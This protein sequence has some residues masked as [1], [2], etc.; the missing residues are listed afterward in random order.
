MAPLCASISDVL[1]RRSGTPDSF[2]A[3][4]KMSRPPCI[5]LSSRVFDM[6]VLRPAFEAACPAIDLRIGSDVEA[7]G[8]L[9]QI[10]AAVCW[11]PSHGLLARLPRLKLVQSLAAT[12]A[13]GM[14]A[15]VTWAVVQHHRQMQGY[16]ANRAARQWRE[17]AITPPASHVVGIAGLGALGSA[18]ASALVA[19]GYTVR[20]WSRSPRPDLPQGVIGFHGP[21]QLDPFLAGCHALVCLL[22]LTP[23]TLGFL[24]AGCFDKLA[25]G[26]HIVNVGRGDHLVEADL[27]AALANGQVGAATLDTFSEEPLPPGHAFW[28]EPKILVTPH[29]ATRSAP[30]VM[31][32]QT[33]ANLDAVNRGVEPMNRVDLARGY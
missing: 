23:D 1:T 3:S 5:A 11:H 16:V 6:R 9:S 21:D 13:S 30:A 15:Y 18:A 12:M 33:L 24:N 19:I 4:E 20:G 8:D 26:A 17:L 10:D 7:L 25:R 14:T 22:P 2:T 28:G 27:L 31:V 29:I 32:A